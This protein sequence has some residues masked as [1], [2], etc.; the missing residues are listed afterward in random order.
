MTIISPLPFQF[1]NGTTIDA[2]EVNADFAQVVAN[3]N[4]NAAHLG[5]NS[6]ITSL[7]GL[8]TPLSTGQGGTGR[9]TGTPALLALSTGSTTLAA[10]GTWYFAVGQMTNGSQLLALIRAPFSGTLKNM[11]AQGGA[12]AGVGNTFTY[13][14]QKNLVDTTLTCQTTGAGAPQSADTTHSVA[15]TAGDT[16]AIKLDISAGATTTDHSVALEFDVTP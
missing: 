10:P 16:L 3:A 8:T 9:N 4:A 11:Y 14:L 1:V 6:D 15:V 13:T 12:A 5:A 7:S 2:T